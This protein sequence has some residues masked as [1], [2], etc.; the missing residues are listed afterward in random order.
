M[1]CGRETL[2]LSIP[3]FGSQAD[4]LRLKRQVNNRVKFASA[5]RVRCVHQ[6]DTGNQ[7]GPLLLMASWY[8]GVRYVG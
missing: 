7:G 8:D 4:V 3:S 6:L 2:M 1:S 5:I